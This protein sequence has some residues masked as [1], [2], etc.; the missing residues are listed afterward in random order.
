MKRLVGM[1]TG[2]IFPFSQSPLT[3][4][5][6]SAAGQCLLLDFLL[7]SAEE[8]LSRPF[9]GQQAEQKPNSRVSVVQLEGPG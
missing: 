2:K 7:Q 1:H 9:I 3:R 6:S 5:T 4:A 8:A